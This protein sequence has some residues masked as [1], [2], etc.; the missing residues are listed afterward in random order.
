MALIAAPSGQDTLVI[1]AVSS[2]WPSEETPVSLAPYLKLVNHTV[3]HRTFE[4]VRTVW[5]D[6]ASTAADVTNLQVFRDLFSS[7]VLRPGE[8]IS[9]GSV[10]LMFTDLR[11]S[12]KLYRL[13]GDATAFGRVREHF[14]VLEKS[15]AEEGGA[16]IKTMGDSVM[17]AFRHPVQ[18]LRA[19]RI[20]Q[21]RLSHREPRLWLKAGIHVGPCIVVN[22]NQRLDY[23]GSTVNLAA[24][25]PD[26]SSGGEIIFSEAIRHDP[27]VEAFLS[28]AIAPNA[29]SHFQAEVRGL[30]EP[31]Q[32]W[33]IKL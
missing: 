1:E 24:R 13:I 12:T 26:F 22:L 27:D 2:G 3:E 4:L 5:S 20:A 9:V 8:E 10:T 25:L 29:L 23:F 18:A 7:E 17:A 32:L 21:M 31:M 11:D 15:V 14:D 6:Q 19:M 28:Q 16:L 30:D 33:K